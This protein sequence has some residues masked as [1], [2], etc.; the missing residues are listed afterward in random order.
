MATVDKDFCMSSFLMYRYI[1]KDGISFDETITPSL[2]DT[3]SVKRNP[4]KNSADLDALIKNVIE[5]TLKKGKVALMLSGGIDSA[6]L[7]KYLPEGTKAFTLKCIAD[8]AEDETQ[9][10]AVYAKECRLDHEI[11]EVTWDD[12]EIFAPELMLHKGAPIHSIEP[13][14]YKAAKTAK[15]QGIDYLLFGE[16]ADII[17]GGMDGLLKKDWSF[18]EFVDRY[19]Y[20]DPEKVLVQGKK[21]LDPFEEFRKN[22]NM[23]DFV[24]FINKHFYRE[25]CG[26]YTNSCGTAQIEYVS[27]YT[28]SYLDADLDLERIRSGDTKY[29]VRE[30]YRKLYPNLEWAPKLPMPRPVG[31]WL[32][33][34]SGPDRSEFIKGCA[35]GLSANQRWMLY[36]LEK[37]LNLLEKRKEK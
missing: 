35:D 18:D 9:R 7:A 23:I 3:S 6:I 28:V 22:E 15:A 25:A 32:K 29:I 34:W 20:V 12:Y 24:G 37:F 14:I 30:L 5:S 13:Q 26:S 31:Q 36:S 2:F 1:Y 33:N 11:I 8:G 16:N 19:S 4:V 10:A 17:Y 27:P 21:Y